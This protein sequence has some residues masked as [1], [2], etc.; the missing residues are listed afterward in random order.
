MSASQLTPESSAS[1]GEMPDLKFMRLGIGDSI[2]AKG[3]AK[4]MSDSFGER[5]CQLSA[6]HQGENRTEK[7]SSQSSQTW[8]EVSHPISWS[9]SW[10]KYLYWGLMGVVNGYRCVGIWWKK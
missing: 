10:K 8:V 7:T 6:P 4:K 9:V 3:G 5:K 2:K 1:E